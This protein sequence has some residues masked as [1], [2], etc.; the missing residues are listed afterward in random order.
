MLTSLSCSTQ[1]TS[2]EKDT[3]V[4]SI[5]G[6]KCCSQKLK[7]QIKSQKLV[8]KVVR[9]MLMKKWIFFK[10]YKQLNDLSLKPL[11]VSNFEAIKKLYEVAMFMEVIQKL[12][13][14]LEKRKQKGI[15]DKHNSAKS[16]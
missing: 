1:H 7:N 12:A 15:N 4:V 10:K 9:D 3:I 14:A 13:E 2:L 6:T 11:S 16:K 8:I 5:E